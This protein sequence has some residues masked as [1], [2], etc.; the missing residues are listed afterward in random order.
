[1]ANLDTRRRSRR[2]E[3]RATPAE[4]DLN[5]RAAAAGGTDRTTFVVTDAV[6]AARR[7]LADRTVFELD[8]DGVAEW[9]A[10][11]LSLRRL[12]HPYEAPVLL[13]PEHLLESLAVPPSRPAG[14]A[15]SPARPRRREHRAS[16]DRSPKAT[17][18]SPPPQAHFYGSGGTDRAARRR[19]PGCCPRAPGELTDGRTLPPWGPRTGRRVDEAVSSSAQ[20]P[21]SPTPR[22]CSPGARCNGGCQPSS[23]SASSTPGISRPHRPLSHGRGDNRPEKR[24][25]LLFVTDGRLEG[26]YPRRCARGPSMCCRSSPTFLT[27]PAGPI[28]SSTRP[29]AAGRPACIGARIHIVHAD[30][31]RDGQPLEPT[32]TEVGRQLAVDPDV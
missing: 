28:A 4:S 12:N 30:V 19:L 1:M 27:T 8:A 31:A 9:D 13:G 15:A 24:V 18:S 6:E 22:H 16:G 5:D 25:R 7:V 2:L 21:C 26:G 17:P 14:C 32:H 20:P 29:R 3:P 11:T 10:A 23:S